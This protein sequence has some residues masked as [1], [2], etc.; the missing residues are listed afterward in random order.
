M[1]VKKMKS[2]LGTYRKYLQEH[3]IP[4]QK[5]DTN[6]KRHPRRKQ[7][8]HLHA[9]LDEME[10]FLRQKHY[11][12]VQRWIGFIQGVLSANGIFSVNELKNHSRPDK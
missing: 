9:M 8:A 5:F 2:V 12:K 6:R 4:K 7:L 1:T 11:S 10:V 3:N